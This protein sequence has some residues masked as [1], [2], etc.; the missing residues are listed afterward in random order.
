MHRFIVAWA[1]TAIAL[2]SPNLT[3]ASDQ[4]TAKQI[5]SSLKQSGRLVGFSIGV[6]FHEGTAWLKGRVSSEQQKALAVEMAEQMPDVVQVVDELT[7]EAAASAAPA[8]RPAYDGREDEAM[9]RLA[10]QQP[11]VYAAKAP[12]AIAA[13]TVR[14][15]EPTVD[16]NV[17]TTAGELAFPDSAFEQSAPQLASAEP[18]I[19][20][21]S[22]K[23]S[24]L[25][26]RGSSSQSKAQGQ[27]DR[28]ASQASAAPTVHSTFEPAPEVATINGQQV[29]LIAMTRG[30]DGSLVPADPAV[31]A[32]FAQNGQQTQLVPLT[33]G[34]NQARTGTA[35]TRKPSILRR[36]GRPM[37]IATRGQ[38]GQA[39]Q[40]AYRNAGGQ[41]P[42]GP[43]PALDGVPGAP[44]PANVPA[45][46]AGPAPAYYDQPN[47]PNYAWPSY[48]AYPNYAAVTYPKQYS[49]TAWPYIGPFY[50]YPQVP[51]G[52][53]KVTLEWDDG[54]WFLDF[55]DK[56]CQ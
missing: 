41:F 2:L 28:M 4:E 7:I 15:T 50:P 38:G 36:R 18:T 39:M 19:Q 54:W 16:P 55:D 53:R 33:Q 42:V 37:P 30:P 14:L 40:T 6:K 29:R 32:Q 26:R 35:Q 22:A 47:M 11:V 17:H 45:P 12:R 13:A 3:R 21:A 52:W 20:V 8:L 24:I 10:P 46:I 23:R 31:A 56:N 49:P 43:V 1:I 27:G 48:A 51:L 9:G 25:R 34:A 5:A 44:L